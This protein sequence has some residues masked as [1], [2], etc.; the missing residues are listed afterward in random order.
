VR[1][2][3]LGAALALAGTLP[4]ASA[5]VVA[6]APVSTQPLAPGEVLLELNATGTVVTRADAAVMTLRAM[7]SGNTAAEARAAA[8]REAARLAGIA[9]GAGVAPA[10]VQIM[11]VMLSPD[12]ADLVGPPPY[13]GADMNAVSVALEDDAARPRTRN[14]TAMVLIR[15]RDLASLQ[16]MIRAMEQGDAVM[17]SEPRYS[18]RDTDAARREARNRALA[19]ARADAEAYAAALGLRVVRVVRVTERLGFDFISMMVNERAMRRQIEANDGRSPDI[20]TSVTIGV[21]F[22]LAPR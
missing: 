3:A 10:D 22:A 21:D 7:G 6:Q 1:L 12:Y 17:E 13:D 20:E 9:R 15:G 4:G 16:P 11:P 8:E 5:V 19:N 2:V 14:A 18:L